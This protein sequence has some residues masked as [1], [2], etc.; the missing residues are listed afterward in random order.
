MILAVGAAKRT[1]LVVALVAF[2]VML[3]LTI[4][5]VLPREKP[6]EEGMPPVEVGKRE[7]PAAPT[8]APGEGG[9]AAAAK[10]AAKPDDVAAQVPGPE[11]PASPA[12]AKPPE[13][14]KDQ[15]PDAP[16]KA[17]PG[18]QAEANAADLYR[19]AF[20]LLN[21][22]QRKVMARIEKVAESGWVA[23]DGPVENVLA[24]NQPAFEEF[25]KA[26]A[27]FKCRFIE[28]GAARGDAPLPHLGQAVS[29]ASLVVAE[30]RMLAAKGDQAAAA[31]RYL[32]AMKLAEH[33]RQ[34]KTLACL[35]HGQTV[36]S[37][38]F[39]AL[40]E[41][42][43]EG[44]LGD[45]TLEPALAQ[46]QRFEASGLA[47]GDCMAGEITS[48][49]RL[50]RTVLQNDA[51]LTGKPWRPA[52]PGVAKA[53]L[54]RVPVEKRR[55]YVADALAAFDDC[56]V[57]IFSVAQSMRREELE[58]LSADLHK[59]RI[60][61]KAPEF[62]GK[63]GEMGVYLAFEFVPRLGPKWKNHAEDQLK[64][65]V[66]LALTGVRLWRSKHGNWP[67][68]LQALV[69]SL[70]KA[71]PND[72]F[73]PKGGELRY[74]VVGV[75]AALWSVGD[76]GKDDAATSASKTGVAGKDVVYWLR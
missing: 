10:A 70:L 43:Q 9:P 6:K 53:A 75:E 57:R 34:D 25:R 20:G 72:P 31:A 74:R 30:G 1:P 14:P 44:K 68:S 5:L 41:L 60:R 61:T 2:L 16:A 58:R 24:E 4:A 71:V 63:P 26:T 28:Q 59:M 50:A 46:F 54:L 52:L 15:T 23:D 42:L 48:V 36:L 56:C 47:L 22:R 29:L 45:E 32:G 35:E 3:G 51:Y 39:P 76:D 18:A 11:A 40:A 62:G 19:K 33:I 38:A 64:R 13:P 67:E 69:P 37:T 12:A 65:R 73:D 55:K 21:I 7:G 66:L 27:C 8:V 49:T 17:M